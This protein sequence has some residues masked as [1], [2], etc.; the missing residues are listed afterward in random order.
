[1]SSIEYVDVATAKAAR[2]VRIVVSG[3]VPSAWSEAT[4]GLFRIANVPVL[5][6][7]RMRDATEINAWTGVDNVPVVLHEGEPP[8]TGWA[9]ITS[10]AS[11][12]A[13]PGVLLPDDIAARV[14]VMGVLNEIAGEDGIGW[15][16]RHAMLEAS[17]TSDGKRGFPAGVAQYLA[18]RYGYVPGQLE[19]VRA[20]TS[21]QLTMLTDRLH[22]RAYF[23]GDRPNA[24]DVYAATFLTPVCEIP[25]AACPGLSP[26]M[27]HAFASA[28]EE[29]GSLVS[30]E[31]RA[32][33]ARMFERHLAWPISL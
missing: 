31:L 8:R 13:G 7:R 33:R 4:K 21:A 19:R 10:L 17:F 23:G 9:A 2:G 11:R 16:G 25:E 14:D 32:H 28:H 5:A 22:G 1:M 12:L 3:L 6:V 15:N 30:D 27:R 18:V 20:R 24:I 29:L 26:V